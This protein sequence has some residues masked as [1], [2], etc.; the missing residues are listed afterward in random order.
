[1]KEDTICQKSRQDSGPLRDFSLSCVT[2][3]AI[4]VIQISRALLQSR[5]IC[6]LSLKK[7]IRWPEN[8]QNLLFL[9]CSGGSR[10]SDK[11]AG[12]IQTLRV[13][14]EGG[15]RSPKK[16]F[17][18][19]GPHFG[20]KITGGGWTPRPPPLNPPV[21]CYYSPSGLSPRAL[22]RIMLTRATILRDC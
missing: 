10:P 7:P 19:V 16:Y 18:P 3:R 20:L 2:P 9:D 14:G 21:D 8:Q 4:M 5:R 15:G 12:V 22:A 11:G 17:Q 13:T 6:L 1:M